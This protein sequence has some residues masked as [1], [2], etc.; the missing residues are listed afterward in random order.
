[1]IRCI[2]IDDEPFAIELIT[3]YV[4]QTPIL[5]L[6]GS[7]NDSLKAIEFIQTHEIDLIFLDI[8]MP[9]IN[10]IQLLKSLE[11]PPMVIFSTAFNEYAVEGF[12]LEAIDYL[13]KPFDIKRFQKA[14]KKADELFSLKKV[15]EPQA[16]PFIFV[17]ADYQMLKINISSIMFIEGWDDYIKI[18]V[19]EKPILTLMSLKSIM[20]QL[21]HQ[22][23]VRVH[24]SYIV[25][26]KKIDSVRN[27]MIRIGSKEIPVG[28]TYVE[29]LNHLMNKK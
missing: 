7:F 21:P 22:E 28:T 23:F 13:L 29:T 14:V 5:N 6:L 12:E 26:I 25:P 27:K 3:F 9:H 11:K 17:K 16:E 15:I 20:E 10:G 8:Q 4:Q 19:G 1:M 18:Y 2:I 24:R